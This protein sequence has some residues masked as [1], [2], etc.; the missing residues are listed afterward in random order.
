MGRGIVSKSVRAQN[1]AELAGNPTRGNP[2]AGRFGRKRPTRSQAKERAPMFHKIIIH[3]N[4]TYR[5]GYELDGS[6][7]NV[8]AVVSYGDPLDT[9]SYLVYKNS[10]PI[11]KT[12]ALKLMI[13]LNVE[14]AKAAQ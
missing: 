11:C 6:M 13:T 10:S 4:K 8:I 7:L 12:I 1:R 14:A 5:V 9:D 3:E 2:N